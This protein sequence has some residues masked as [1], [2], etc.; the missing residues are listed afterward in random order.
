[1]GIVRAERGTRECESTFRGVKGLADTIA[2]RERVARMVDLIENDEGGSRLGSRSVQ[3]RVRPHLRVREGNALIVIAVPTLGIR[4]V[5]VDL[6]AHTQRG[7]RPLGLQVLGRGNHGN[8]AH[9]PFLEQARGDLQSKGCFASAR[10]R[11]GHEVARLALLVKVQGFGLPRTEL[12]RRAP[13][14]ALGECGRHLLRRKRRGLAGR[15]LGVNSRRVLLAGARRLQ[16]TREQ[17]G[18]SGRIVGI[19]KRHP[20]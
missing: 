9:D 3:P 6:N 19:H 18:R 4:E 7:I 20:R 5:R 10:G 8:A 12:R 14:C 13:R 16:I 2:P 15:R 11:H 1:M 17:V